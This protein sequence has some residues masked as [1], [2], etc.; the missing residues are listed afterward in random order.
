[1][2]GPPQPRGGTLRT[3]RAAD[4]VVLLTLDRPD[5]GNG[6]V[7]ELAADLTETLTALDAD[8]TVRA[9]VVTGAGPQFSAGA[10]LTA[11]R[12]YVEHE[13]PSPTTRRRSSR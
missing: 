12:E 13:L 9:V 6:V 4:G 10:D 1:M 5:R 3:E 7:P 2:T 8:T 11:M